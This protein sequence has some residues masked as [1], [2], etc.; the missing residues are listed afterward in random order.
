M[1]YNLLAQRAHKHAANARRTTQNLTIADLNDR[2]QK[3]QSPQTL[4]YV[5]HCKNGAE[6]MKVF[7]MRV[8]I[9]DSNLEQPI[10]G[11]KLFHGGTQLVD[12]AIKP[13]EE[14]KAL[15]SIA[16]LNPNAS[17][18]SRQGLSHDQLRTLAQI[19]AKGFIENFFPNHVQPNANVYSGSYG[20]PRENKLSFSLVV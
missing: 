5:L 13:I 10:L 9:D 8:D 6:Q 12:T 1:D 4:A 3:R 19:K 18:L 14:G 7:P 15:S 11:V 17:E 2:L 20:A 16:V